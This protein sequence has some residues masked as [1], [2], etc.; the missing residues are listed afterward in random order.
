MVELLALEQAVARQVR[1]AEH[2]LRQAKKMLDD[3]YGLAASLA[4]CARIQTEQRRAKA[5]RRRL[6]KIVPSSVL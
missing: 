2:S 1:R 6:L 4:L 5:A 3:S